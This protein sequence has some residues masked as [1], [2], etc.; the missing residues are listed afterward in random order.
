MTSGVRLAIAGMVITV[1]TIYMGIVGAAASW[2]YYVTV[3][4][5]L[6]AHSS[7]SESRLRVSGTI[8]AGTL[9]SDPHGSAVSFDLVG[10]TANLHV[11]L[12]GPAPDNLA[13]DREV[14]VEGQ[15]TGDAQLR[16]DRVLTRCASKYTTAN[17]D[18]PRHSETDLASR[19]F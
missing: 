11:R 3:D 13:E 1:L 5:C 2:K 12:S 7:L 14:V 19:G 18:A 9:A 4:E 10:S 17:R 15:L 8:A 16:A 6:E